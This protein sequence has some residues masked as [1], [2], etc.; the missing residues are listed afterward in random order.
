[1]KAK[2]QS[3]EYKAFESLLGKVLTVSKAELQT[4]LDE[5]KREKQTKAASHASGAPSNH[6]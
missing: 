6:T 3:D 4:R 1:M 2:P 5:E